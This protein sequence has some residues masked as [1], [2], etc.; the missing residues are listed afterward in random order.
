[1]ESTP[2][3]APQ[4]WTLAR[5]ASPRFRATSRRRRRVTCRVV[6]TQLRHPPASFVSC[7]EKGTRT[8]ALLLQPGGLKRRLLRQRHDPAAGRWVV[9]TMAPRRRWIREERAGSLGKCEYDYKP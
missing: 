1:M 3:A 5:C 7:C 9:S 4:R 6:I 2:S 8:L